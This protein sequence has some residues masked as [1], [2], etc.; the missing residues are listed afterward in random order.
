[1]IFESK[2]KV[3]RILAINSM[4]HFNK[5]LPVYLPSICT[6]LLLYPQKGV[7]TNLL[8]FKKQKKNSKDWTRKLIY[9]YISN[10]LNQPTSNCTNN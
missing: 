1:M 10:I 2:G 6:F 4:N 9:K 8:I 3:N 5:L 7:I